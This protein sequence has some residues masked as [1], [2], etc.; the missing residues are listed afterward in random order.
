MKGRYFRI[1]SVLLAAALLLMS[2][3]GQ[4]E[5]RR[6]RG[7]DGRGTVSRGVQPPLGLKWKIELQEQDEPASSFN[8]SLILNDTIYFGST[9]GNFYAF[10]IMTG[11][12]KWAFRTGHIINS[13]PYT[14]GDRVYFGSNDG[15]VYSLDLKSGELIWKFETDS[16]VQSLILG[17]DGKIVF[18]SDGGQTYI[19]NRNGEQEY[20]IPNPVWHLHTFQID[21][22]IMYFAP[23]P[24]ENPR[25]FS[26]YNLRSR[27]RLWTVDLTFSDDYWFSLPA[28]SDNLV[29]YA[30]A[31]VREDGWG[32]TFRALD[33]ETGSVRWIRREESDLGLDTGIEI[34]ELFFKNID[35]L[36]Y[37]APSV[38]KNL[39][40]YTSGDRTVR[41]YAKKTGDTAWERTFSVPVSSS[42]LV[43]GNRLYFGLRSGTGNDGMPV[44]PRL[45]CLQASNGHILWE[46]ELEGNLLSSPVIGGNWVVFGT[47]QYMLYVLEELF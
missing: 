5:W 8:N 43:A 6:F 47:D 2:C 31:S 44:P 9:D 46:M 45:V 35:L 11:Y 22:G 14:D 12:M 29:H 36:D 34:I 42:P 41:A 20:T 17:F 19:L 25:S 18:T 26:A 7:E 33:R 16:T 37:Q 23:G 4:N 28:V 40:I 21:D 24:L 3:G 32:F 10:D 39:V 1:P 30:T 15:F 13:I 27:E 38:W